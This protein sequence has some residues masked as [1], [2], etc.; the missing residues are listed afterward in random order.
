[1]QKLTCGF[2]GKEPKVCCATS[3]G[4]Q[5]FEL[6]PT[7]DECGSRKIEVAVRVIGGKKVPLG[8]FP[9]LARIGFRK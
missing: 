8:Y 6:L 1:L 2:K 7:L 3:K 5:N 9:W 4:H